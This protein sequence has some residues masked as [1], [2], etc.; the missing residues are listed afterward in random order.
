MTTV[1]PNRPMSTRQER[2]RATRRTTTSRP[3]GTC[4]VIPG[5]GR[6]PVDGAYV[7]NFSTAYVLDLIAREATP[8]Y[9]LARASE[10]HDLA[11][12]FMKKAWLLEHGTASTYF[13]STAAMGGCPVTALTT[14]V[15]G[16]A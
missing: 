6:V 13:D 1:A 7:D 3:T 9:W 14:S 15:G 16:A 10:M 2:P 4:V 8:A 5:V 12:A 11:I